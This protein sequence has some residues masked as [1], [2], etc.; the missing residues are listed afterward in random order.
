MNE[1]I[2]FSESPSPFTHI[3]MP[4]DGS[5]SSVNAGRLA[6]RVAST[7]AIPLTLLYVVDTVVISQM[8]SVTSAGEEELVQEFERKG[9][10]YLDYLARLAHARGI[11]SEKVI[12]QGLPHRVII[13]VAR[14]LGADLIVIGLVGRGGSRRDHLGSVAQRVVEE[15]PCPV[16]VVRYTPD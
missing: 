8:Q 16:M 10:H 9:A 11:R 13:D 14:E 7:H 15:T 3:L 12:R 5:E 2:D 6:I 1:V 4:T